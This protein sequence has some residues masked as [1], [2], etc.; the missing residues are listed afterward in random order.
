MVVPIEYGNENE[1]QDAAMRTL[2]AEEANDL[3]EKYGSPFYLFDSRQFLSNFNELK[4]AFGAHYPKVKFG[5]SYKTNYLPY[6][7]KSAKKTGVLAEVVS[8]LEYDLALHIGYKP[9]EIIFNGPVKKGIELLSAVTNGSLINLDCFSEIDLIVSAVAAGHVS[10]SD[11]KIGLRVNLNIKDSQGKSAVQN[12]LDVSRFGFSEHDIG[13]AIELLKGI[14]IEPIALHGHTSTSDRAAENFKVIVNSLCA[15]RDENELDSLEF[16]NVGGGLFGDVPRSLIGREVPSFVDYAESIATAL[17]ENSWV[18]QN[19]PCLIVEPG[20]SVVANCF[21]FYSTVHCIK[22]VGVKQFAV[23]DGSIYNIRPTM[24]RYK[25][26]MRK[27]DSG[28][29]DVEKTYDIVGSTCMEKDIL[30]GDVILPE[31]KQ[32][33]VLEVSHVGAYTLVMTPPF[34]NLAPAIVANTDD[35]KFTLARKA[36]SFETFF[37]DY[38]DN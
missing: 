17:Y 10:A 28:G 36:Q 1:N 12:G 2:T 37:T 4:A 22:T 35:N 8:R 18:K 11:A 21:S 31:L 13:K 20:I 34:I 38:T 16:I 23:V 30:A 9:A 26:P 33:D 3:A 6:L 24:H 32:G 15:V 14:G 7:C 25:L 29:E 27:L 19:L 5:Y